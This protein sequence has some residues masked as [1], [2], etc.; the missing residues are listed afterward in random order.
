MR[1]DILKQI[2]GPFSVA[3]TIEDRVL[4]A[5]DRLG[6]HALSYGLKDGVFAFGSSPRSVAAHPAFGLDLNPQAIFNFFFFA[7]VASPSKSILTG[8]A[9]R[10]TV[11]CY[12]R[13]TAV[14]KSVIK[15]LLGRC[16]PLS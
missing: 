13:V 12:R 1:P 7:D 14:L 10:E 11:S 3:A 8:S 4:L 15:R 6:V 2:H 16:P 9:R 5:V